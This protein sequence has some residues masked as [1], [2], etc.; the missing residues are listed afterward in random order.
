MPGTASPLPGQILRVSIREEIY[1]RFDHALLLRGVL[2]VSVHKGNIFLR[3]SGRSRPARTRS[4]VNKRLILLLIEIGP[5]RTCAKGSKRTTTHAAPAGEA[6]PV[7][8]AMRR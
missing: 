7:A 5:L 4:R 2:C 1:T 8:E 6:Q 3:A